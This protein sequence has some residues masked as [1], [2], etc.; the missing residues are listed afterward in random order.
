MW[1]L[2]L[3]L[4]V[5]AMKY[6]WGVKN[7]QPRTADHLQPQSLDLQITKSF[8]NEQPLTW[9]FVDLSFQVTQNMLLFILSLLKSSWKVCWQFHLWLFK[10]LPGYWQQP[11]GEEYFHWSFVGSCQLHRRAS[12]LGAGLAHFYTPATHVQQN[13]CISQLCTHPGFRGSGPSSTEMQNSGC[14]LSS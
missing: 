6:V 10:G 2:S 9:H 7:K 3:T 13:T 14:Y 8:G 12:A 1:F 11:H 4:D 5:M